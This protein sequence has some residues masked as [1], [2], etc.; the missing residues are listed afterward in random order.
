MCFFQVI[1]LAD[2][3]SFNVDDPGGSQQTPPQAKLPARNIFGTWLLTPARK[4]NTGG[5]QPQKPVLTPSGEKAVAAYD[6]FRD[7]PVFRCDPVAVARV[8]QAPSTPLEILR[9]GNEIILHQEW[10]DV[11]R[12]IHMDMKSHPNVGARSP[13]DIPSGIGRATRW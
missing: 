13:S 9:N 3:R 11:R 12:V 2:G 10:M 1:E 8:W 4:R 5:P 7:D 6:T